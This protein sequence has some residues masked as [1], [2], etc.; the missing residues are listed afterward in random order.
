MATLKNKVIVITGAGGS[1]ATAVAQAFAREGACPFLVDRDGVRIQGI[2]ASTSAPSLEADV[3]TP[4][5]AAC[6]VREAKA[7]LGKIDG[8]V[9]L[10]GDPARGSV[11]TTPLEAYDQVFDTNV[12][13]LFYATR[14][15][16]PELVS[17]N[18]G[19]I[20][21]IASREAWG[22]G[23]RNAALFAAAKSAVAAFLRSLDAELQETNVNVSI[24]FPMGAVD[25]PSNHRLFTGSLGETLIAPS[26]IAE[27]FVKVAQQSSGGRLLEVPIYPPRARVLEELLV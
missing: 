14:A 10:V 1:I 15:V 17:R 11:A 4:E 26:V 2:A 19:F 18:E 5:G 21:G 8:L 7:Q 25:T 13:S 16:L 22:G 27:A 3:T 9:H 23:S 6:M 12:R 24:L 20:A